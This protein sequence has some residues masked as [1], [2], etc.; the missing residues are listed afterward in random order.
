MSSTETLIFP[1]EIMSLI[2][3]YTP[4]LACRLNKEFRKI[5]IDRYYQK[6]IVTP[7]IPAEISDY[8][9]TSPTRM[10]VSIWCVQCNSLLV[11]ELYREIKGDLCQEHKSTLGSDR[12]LY[13]N[14]YKNLYQT[15]SRETCRRCCF[16]VN[17]GVGVF[18][19]KTKRTAEELVIA[20][21]NIPQQ[22]RYHPDY[23][24]QFY[25]YRRRGISD[26]VISCHMLHHHMVTSYR[27][28]VGIIFVDQYKILTGKK[29]N[30][31]VAVL[32]LD[33]YLTNLVG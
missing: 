15:I 18:P 19:E 32:K 11:Y 13:R 17:T 4:L 28:D 20:I 2:L 30:K 1:L 3:E 14:L 26:E 27:C 10:S 23:V 25:I 24:A 16:H 21:K 12:N 8:L 7:I 22:Y 29:V 31:T 9:D 33:E 5:Y 6:A